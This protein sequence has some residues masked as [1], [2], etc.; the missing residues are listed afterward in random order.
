MNCITSTTLAGI[1]ELNCGKTFGRQIRSNNKEGKL[2]YGIRH[3]YKDIPPCKAP[4][5]IKYDSKTCNR[6][7]KDKYV[8]F[9]ILNC[10]DVKQRPEAQLIETLGDVDDESAFNNYRVYSAGLSTS[11]SWTKELSTYRKKPDIDDLLNKSLELCES[12]SITTRHSVFTIDPPGCK[13]MDDGI[14]IRTYIDENGDEM[15]SIC[16]AITHVPA[17]LLSSGI[18]SKQL[19]DSLRNTCSLYLTDKVVNMIPKQFAE[20]ICS[21][22][23]GNVKPALVH[24]IIWNDTQKN[25]VKQTLSIECVTITHNYEYECPQLVSQESYRNLLHCVKEMSNKYRMFDACPIIID[26]HD[27]VA[28]L[29]TIMNFF[30]MEWMS[31]HNLPCIY[32]INRKRNDVIFPNEFQHLKRKLGN[33]AGEYCS[34]EN[35]K[36]YI[37]N[38]DVLIWTHITSPMRRLADLT[39]M[40]TISLF[41]QP[42]KYSVLLQFR[43]ACLDMIPR[44]SLEYK[45]S[46]RVSLDCELFSFAKN[47]SDFNTRYNGIVIECESDHETTNHSN[48]EQILIVYVEEVSRLFKCINATKTSY[49]LFDKVTCKLMLFDEGH[50]ITDKVRLMIS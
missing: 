39:N 36:P 5:E 28:Y 18:D 43:D 41:L 35:V 50:L 20:Q 8:L 14:G 7:V 24:C 48:S 6:Y 27:V 4:F 44:I 12:N 40:L 37:G 34:E 23:E 1:L 31:N 29:M 2:F 33:Y 46:R 9:R 26:S 13:D 42:D 38:L 10:D 49:N 21:L 11:S 22:T 47:R 30:V 3:E 16:I 19:S 15:F 45:L 17:F 25:V 32:R